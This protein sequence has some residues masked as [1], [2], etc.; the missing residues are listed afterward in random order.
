MEFIL[1]D[2]L[3]LLDNLADYDAPLDIPALDDSEV[4]ATLNGQSTR[5]HHSPV[6]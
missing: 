3:A 1:Q 5:S 2:E 4:N 6:H